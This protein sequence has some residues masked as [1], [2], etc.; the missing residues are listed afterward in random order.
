MNGPYVHRYDG[1]YVLTGRLDIGSDGRDDTMTRVRL[2]GHLRN[3]GASK[4]CD[5]QWIPTRA[6]DERSGFKGSGRQCPDRLQA[7]AISQSLGT[8]QCWF[9]VYIGQR[10]VLSEA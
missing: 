9:V 4:Q 3:I 7:F 1:D 8:T 6:A 10:C 2:G 5:K